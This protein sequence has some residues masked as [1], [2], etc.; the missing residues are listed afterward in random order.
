MA[1]H[2]ITPFGP[3]LRKGQQF[4]KT[5]NWLLNKCYAEE[6]S[7]RLP[8]GSFGVCYVVCQGVLREWCQGHRALLSGFEVFGCFC[9]GG[10]LWQTREV[11][12]S[13]ENGENTP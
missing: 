11:M 7:H 4:I 6:E 9:F 12:N 1:H 8:D 5:P 2:Q 10:D 3:N 13:V